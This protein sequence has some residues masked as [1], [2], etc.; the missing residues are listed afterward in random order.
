MTLPRVPGFRRWV[1]AETCSSLGDSV[2]F[3]ALAWAATGIG[4]G[5]AGLVLTA[6]SFPLAGLML[7]GGVT[8]D[9][10]GVRAT[11]IACDAAMACVMTVAA[12]LLLCHRHLGLDGHGHHGL[13]LT[14]VSVGVLSGTASAMRRPAAGVFPRLFVEPEHLPQ[15]LATVGAWA[16]VARIA[17]PAAGG[18]LVGAIGVG[19]ALAIDAL[20]FG[21]VTVAL[22]LV[23]PPRPDRAAVSD[24]SAWRAIAAS[25]A[26]ARRTPGVPACLLAV[27]GLAASVLTFVML[28][29]PAFGHERD[30]GPSVTGQVSAAW[31]AGS[32][33]VTALV[34][35][36]G[37]RSRTAMCVGPL[38]G[39][40]GAIMLPPFG[41]VVV[42]AAGVGLVG[43]GT[44]LTTTRLLPTF[45]V[46]TPAPMLARFQALLQVAQTGATMVTMPVVGL[47]VSAAGPDA[48]TL[49]LAGVMLA[50]TGPLVRLSR[51]GDHDPG[52]PVHR[53]GRGLTEGA[54]GLGEPIDRAP[55]LVLGPG[56]GNPDEGVE[57]PVDAEHRSR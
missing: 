23:L 33:V 2:S 42:S 57:P 55:E 19:G 53:V 14:L 31:V 44:A 40:G 38:L 6:E 1:A 24:E 21:L 52:G 37:A 48:G 26:A 29:V 28:V 46:L 49:V 9:R 54:P 16:Q 17:G 51:S 4:G 12:V 50:T 22:A 35:R 20:S 41:A 15:V 47:V 43:V 56:V 27:V 5:T 18:A 7:I 13:T 25:V 36:R 3:F 8:A 10:R 32:L 34:A 45:Q 30:W 11:M 39:A